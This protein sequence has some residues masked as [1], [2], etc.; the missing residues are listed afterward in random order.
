MI[1][2]KVS[3]ITILLLLVYASVGQECFQRSIAAFHNS[4]VHVVNRVFVSGS[5]VVSWRLR[6][7]VF[8]RKNRI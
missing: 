6:N 2:K 3:K 8:R 7:P 4:K 1:G 5:Q